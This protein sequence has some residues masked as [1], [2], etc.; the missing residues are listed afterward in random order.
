MNEDGGTGVTWK[1]THG[2]ELA[3]SGTA[4]LSRIRVVLAPW[5]TTRTKNLGARELGAAAG[6]D[7]KS[8]WVSWVVIVK[9]VS[10]DDGHHVVASVGPV[11][12]VDDSIF[13]ATLFQIP[14]L[15]HRPVWL[16]WASLAS[17]QNLAHLTG[18]TKSIGR[19]SSQEAFQQLNQRLLLTCKDDAAFEVD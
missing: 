8:D 11:V 4:G 5:F 19:T 1:R 7:A 3:A 13:Q 14:E 12:E 6:E 16:T 9:R 2:S 18:A 15:H 17:D 10:V